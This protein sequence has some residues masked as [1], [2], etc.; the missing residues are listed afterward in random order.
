M[1]DDQCNN[2][3]ACLAGL[4][5]NKKVQFYVNGTKN[6]AGGQANWK[7]LKGAHSRCECKE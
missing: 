5:P 6:K 3:T 7:A 4:S 2:T 1:A